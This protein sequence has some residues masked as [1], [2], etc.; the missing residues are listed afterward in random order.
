M[1]SRGL[2]QVRGGARVHG[3]HAQRP[4]AGPLQ[5]FQHGGWQDLESSALGYGHG[6]VEMGM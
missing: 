1:P 4:G 3:F 2:G 6:G 5:G